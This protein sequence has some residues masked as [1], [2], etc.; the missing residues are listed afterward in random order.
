LSNRVCGGARNR[1]TDDPLKNSR[2]TLASY[3]QEQELHITN[4]TK[5]KYQGGVYP[6]HTKHFH[7]AQPP[8][9]APTRPRARGQYQAQQT[10][11][12]QYSPTQLPGHGQSS[13]SQYSQQL[14]SPSYQP[15]HAPQYPPSQRPQPPANAPDQGRSTSKRQ[16]EAYLRRLRQRRRHGRCR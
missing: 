4:S 5:R 7:L 12:L 2:K 10:Y 16:P 8:A 13:S 14:L 11:S 15:Y 3:E 6:T 9:G 1:V